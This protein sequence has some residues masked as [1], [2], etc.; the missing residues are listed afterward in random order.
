[1]NNNNRFVIVTQQ[2]RDK[3][4]LKNKTTVILKTG[5]LFRRFDN[6]DSAV[7]I[8]SVCTIVLPRLHCS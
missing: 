6:I 7:I 1:M 2:M 3:N 4:N 5:L 8:S